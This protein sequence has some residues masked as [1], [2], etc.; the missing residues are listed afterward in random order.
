MSHLITTATLRAVGANVARAELWLEPMRA[1]ADV[2]DIYTPERV[3]AFLAQIGHESAGLKYTT[4][5]WGPS[6]AQRRY[7]GREDL[8]N[9]QP[10]DGARYKGH[11]LIQTTGRANHARVRD[12]LRQRLGDWVPDFEAHPELLA[13]HEWA[14][15]SAADYWDDR[16]LNA[17]A[18]A[19]EFERITRRINGGLNGQADRLAKWRAVRAELGLA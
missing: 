14:A 6:P 3:A 7:E 17:L 11:G 2:Y 5:L 18:D 1:A 15:L 4:E 19:G 12:R 9:T 16:G 8:G 13:T 10:G